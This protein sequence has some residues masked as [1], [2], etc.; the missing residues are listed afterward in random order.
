MRPD[1]FQDILGESFVTHSSETVLEIGAQ[2]YDRFRL[3]ELGVPQ[4]KAA[5]NLHRVL[6][7]LSINSIA[8]LAERVHELVRVRGL[9][10]AAFYAAMAILTDAN[11]EKAARAAYTSAAERNGHTVTFATIHQRARKHKRTYRSRKPT[12]SK[13]RLVS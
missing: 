11:R 9:G 6:V 13:M 7:R 3:G 8:D 2:H 1:Y 10:H 5:R 4:I 12:P